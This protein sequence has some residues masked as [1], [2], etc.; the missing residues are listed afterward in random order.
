MNDG[1]GVRRS[2]KQSPKLKKKSQSLYRF[3]DEF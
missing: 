2:N 3:T 1:E